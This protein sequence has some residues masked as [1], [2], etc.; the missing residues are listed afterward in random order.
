VDWIV[1]N[2]VG[3][4][5][6]G[7]FLGNTPVEV[8]TTLA[9]VVCPGFQNRTNTQCDTCPYSKT[10]STTMCCCH[11]PGYNLGTQ[12]LQTQQN[13]GLTLD[14]AISTVL[15]YYQ[16]G[17]TGQEGLQPYYYPEGVYFCYRDLLDPYFMSLQVQLG[18]TSAQFIREPQHS[19]GSGTPSN[20]AYAFEFLVQNQN[21]NYN[22]DNFCGSS[23]IAVLNPLDHLATYTSNGYI[24]NPS[25]PQPVNTWNPTPSYLALFQLNANAYLS[26]DAA[27]K[28]DSPASHGALA[29]AIAVPIIVAAVIAAVAAVILHRRARHMP[30]QDQA[31]DTS[32]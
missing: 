15:S 10:G 29:A 12:I 14:A 5:V 2:G 3:Q 13:N 24:V 16:T 1:K 23:E 31:A 6:N 27:T 21:W 20:P 8:F 4:S 25:N 19:G 17:M 11:G 7:L 32:L 26:S 18:F 9:N 28:N 22:W 30:L